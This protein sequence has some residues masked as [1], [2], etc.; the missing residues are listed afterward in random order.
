MSSHTITYA[1]LHRRSSRAFFLARATQHM[2][3]FGAAR[4]VVRALAALAAVIGWGGVCLL[5]AG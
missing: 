5:V 2:E 1:L 3:S 4:E